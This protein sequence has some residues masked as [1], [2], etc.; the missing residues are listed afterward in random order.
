MEVNPHSSVTH[1]AASHDVHHGDAHHHE[2]EH[3][4]NFWTKYVFTTD[5][6]M[7]GK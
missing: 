2:H 1:D 3:E 7:I 5:H 6:K 4:D